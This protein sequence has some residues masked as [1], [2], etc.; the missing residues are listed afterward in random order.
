MS[1]IIGCIG[2]TSLAKAASD[3]RSRLQA[4]ER[5]MRGSDAV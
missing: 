1:L 5:G 4:A 2:L 3:R